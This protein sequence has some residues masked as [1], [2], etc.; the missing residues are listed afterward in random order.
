MNGLDRANKLVHVEPFI[1][2]DGVAV[3][4]SP[5]ISAVA[6]DPPER[7]GHQGASLLARH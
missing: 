4:S 7:P 2:E 1:D 5:R 3:A 6:L